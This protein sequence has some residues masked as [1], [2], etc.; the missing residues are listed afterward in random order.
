MT[1]WSRSK[2][3]LPLWLNAYADWIQHRRAVAKNAP[4]DS[5]LESRVYRRLK[6][7]SLS[8][9]LFY[10]LRERKRD[11]LAENEHRPSQLSQR[12]Q[13]KNRHNQYKRGLAA[14]TI[15]LGLGTATWTGLFVTEQVTFGGVP[16]R[17]VETFWNDK[18]ARDAYFSGETQALHDQ[19]SA[20]GVEEAIKAYYRDQF[21]N[22]HEL[23][24][25]IHQIMFDRTGYVGEAY[26]VN[27]QGQL[28]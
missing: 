12:L 4:I 25:H 15:G 3:H 28:Y 16:Y 14:A 21:D 13:D 11:R 7:V 27:N 2:L 19:L 18:T 6:D 26:Q 10:T 22:E 23:D 20:L 1:R 24:K 17:I 5:E 8:D 9:R